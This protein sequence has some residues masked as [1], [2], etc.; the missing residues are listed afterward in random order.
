M[1][2]LGTYSSLSFGF[3]FMGPS[4][5][6]GIPSFRQEMLLEYLNG[7]QFIEEL[8]PS[9]N[10]LFC[11]VNLF[12]W[13]GS[14]FV[15]VCGCLVSLSCLTLWDHMDYRLQDS[16]VHRDSSAKNGSGFPC[17]SPED[18]P[19]PGIKLRYPTLQMDSLPSE[20]PGKLWCDLFVPLFAEICLYLLCFSVIELT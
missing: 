3:S 2:T 1:C 6:I 7:N 18:L 8:V 16:S 10:H 15:C 14:W 4:N 12:T 19:N 5:L 11:R 20:P 17:S 9:W 13:V